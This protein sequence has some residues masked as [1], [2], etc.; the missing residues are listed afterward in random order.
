MNAEK[1]VLLSDKEAVLREKTELQREFNRSEQEK[2]DVNTKKSG[3][4]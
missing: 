1:Q 3:N 2:Q 4:C